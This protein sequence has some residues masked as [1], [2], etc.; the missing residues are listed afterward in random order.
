M[1]KAIRDNIINAKRLSKA[2]KEESSDTEEDVPIPPRPPKA[3]KKLSDVVPA[4]SVAPVDG[5]VPEH[6][7]CSYFRLFSDNEFA[8]LILPANAYT[9]YQ[10]DPVTF[11]DFTVTATTTIPADQHESIAKALSCKADAIGK[12]FPKKSS[13]FLLRSAVPLNI[14]ARKSE[15]IGNV[16]VIQIPFAAASLAPL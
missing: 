11:T 10:F 4:S 7:V 13:K 3:L 9:T 14:F 5:V 15:T 12:F 1:C 6:S 2:A 16:H 8:C